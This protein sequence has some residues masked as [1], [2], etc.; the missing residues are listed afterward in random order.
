MR[1]GSIK[2]RNII[3]VQSRRTSLHKQPQ[4]KDIHIISVV[5]KGNYVYIIH[6]P[7]HLVI[8]TFKINISPLFTVI[9]LHLQC[10]ISRR[11][12]CLLYYSY[13]MQVYD[14]CLHQMY[15]SEVK[16]VLDTPCIG[17]MKIS[18]VKC[19]YFIIEKAQS[20]CTRRVFLT[21]NSIIL[22]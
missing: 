5:L 18:A 6:L 8:I 11:I 22:Y 3:N 7:H 16:F 10:I 12:E 15:N 19:L 4:P 14:K 13:Y 2:R 21:Y 17:S 1:Y 20:L 9:S